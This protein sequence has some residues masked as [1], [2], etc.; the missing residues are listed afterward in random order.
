LGFL[1]NILSHPVIS[2][3]I[4][5]SGLLIAASQIKTIK[6]VKAEGHNFVEL[7]LSLALQI[8]NVHLLT[9]VVG[10][11]ATAFLFW[12]RKGLKPLLMRLGLSLRAADVLAKAGTV[13]AIAATTLAA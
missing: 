6:G 1:A 12:V 10:V 2:G 8:P 7:A 9:L 3:F 5:A 4:S 11:A 13:V